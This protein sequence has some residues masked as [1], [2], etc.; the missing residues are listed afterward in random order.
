MTSS[1]EYDLFHWKIFGLN[2]ELPST[3]SRL[4]KETC[5][6]CYKSFTIVIYNQNDCGQDYKTTISTVIYDPS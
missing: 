4:Q 2:L 5:G 3:L 1:E 6:L